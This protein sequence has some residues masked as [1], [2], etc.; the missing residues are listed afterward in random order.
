MKIKKLIFLILLI[1]LLFSFFSLRGICKEDIVEMPSGFG[2]AVQALPDDVVDKLPE[3]IYSDDADRVGIAL[4][5]IASPKYILELFGELIG[6]GVGAALSLCALLCSIL[7]VAALCSAIKRSVGSEALSSALGFCVNAVLF[8]AI[9]G[10]VCAQIEMVRNFFERLNSLM[11]SMI[12]VFGA[13]YVSGGNLATATASGSSMYL[14]IAVSET[15]CAKSIVPIA[16]IC[17]ALA[18]CRALSPNI[19]LQSI[20]NAIKKSYALILG[21]IMSLLLLLLAGETSLTA[22]ADS[23]G[24]RAAK[25]LTAS[26]IPV[27][28]GSVAE[29]LRTAAAGVQYIKT[30]V[31]VGGVILVVLLLLPTLVSLL[32]GRLAFLGAGAVGGLLGCDDEVRLL[33]DIGG[34]YGS[35]I[36]AVAMCSVM[37]IFAMNIFVKTTVAI[38]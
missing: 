7:I 15:F 13:V 31:G 19:E 11:Y 2:D 5:G 16:S 26:M 14:F 6:D 35:M 30:V 27:V 37:F 3:E 28:G 36:A 33:G 4:E 20:G 1:C 29:T 23:V 21:L 8:A 12:P 34:I 38:G 25:M 17:T 18:L 24:S 10:S 9:V 22:A 32:L